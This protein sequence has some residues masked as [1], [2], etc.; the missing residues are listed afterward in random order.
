MGTTEDR[1]FERW[2]R[3]SD[4]DALG[5]L[6][7]LA[8]P[9][10]LRLAIHLVGEPSEAEDLVQSTFLAA[11]EQRAS[12][13]SHRPV[14]PWLTAVLS[15]K[16]AD[17]KRRA[18][19]ELDLEGLLKSPAE[20]AS[21]PTERRELSGELAKAID[22]LDEPYRQVMILRLRHGL[23]PA[24]IAHVLE[25]GAVELISLSAA[26]GPSDGPS[27]GPGI[28]GDGRFVCFES[29]TTN[30]VSP[31]ASGNFAIFVRDRLTGLTEIASVN[32]AGVQANNT[33]EISTLSANGRFV[34]FGSYADNLVLG[35]AF[36]GVRDVYLRDRVAHSTRLVSRRPGGPQANSSSSESSVSGDGRLVAFRSQADNLVAGGTTPG[37]QHVYLF[38]A[39]TGAI[40]LMSA[41][42][43]GAEA[44]GDSYKPVLSANGRFLAFETYSTNLL[45]PTSPGASTVV[46]RDLTSGAILD[47]NKDSLGL[48]I[49]MP[50]M[51]PSL[52][53]NGRFVAF[54]SGPVLPNSSGGLYVRDRLLGMT[55][56]ACGQQNGNGKQAGTAFDARIS[57][58]GTTVAINTLGQLVPGVPFS[59]GDVYVRGIGAPLTYCQGKTN[60][61]G[62]V[63]T[64]GSSGEA[65]VS[66]GFDLTV[67]GSNAVNNMVGILLHG[68][69]GP[70]MAPFGAGLLCVAPPILRSMP[71]GS[72]GT[73]PPVK[74]CSGVFSLDL[75]PVLASTP[76]GQTV[77]AGDVLYLQ[78]WGRDSGFPPPDGVQLSDALQIVIG[79]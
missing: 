8:S 14:L 71:V 28:S 51:Q 15:R 18:R 21:V 9:G 31:P 53:A 47:V 29:G 1:L 50:T 61:Q 25:R 44:N 38:D 63:P 39:V 60:S 55:I 41:A 57:G 77:W 68:L 48:P 78:W 46:L 23:S 43:N 69:A 58:D 17:S 67:T 32:A 40:T 11:I 19:R 2:C 42:A 66:N 76:A 73:P 36:S 7:D 65:R 79:P 45:Q 34:V 5:E 35:H 54:R 22:A 3:Q 26:G 13:D 4:A 37:R 59:Q 56:A 52:S 70:R 6:F 72:G 30:L 33:S 49:T 16:A 10:L 74:D 64:I 27:T 12:V 20:D 75:G 62:C 24:D